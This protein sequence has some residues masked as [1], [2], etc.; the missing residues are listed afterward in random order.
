MRCGTKGCVFLRDSKQHLCTL[1]SN[2]PKYDSLLTPAADQGSAQS[3]LC[4]G[5]QLLSEG[6]LG[7]FPL[8][9]NTRPISKA[10]HSEALTSQ[11]RA[12]ESRQL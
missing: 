10:K 4:F 6:W 2:R 1:S 7:T 8:L 5:T 3:R 9:Q 11:Q 12:E